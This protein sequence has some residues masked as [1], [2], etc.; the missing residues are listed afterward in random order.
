MLDLEGI[1]GDPSNALWP[2]K[3][4]VSL[5]TRDDRE[6]VVPVRV[7][8]RIAARRTICDELPVGSKAL[9]CK[10]LSNGDG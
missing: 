10:L 6:P 2:K 8:E 7:L 4:E 9:L 1:R 5:L 3:H